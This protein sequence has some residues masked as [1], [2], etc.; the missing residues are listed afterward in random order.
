[1]HGYIAPCMAASHAGRAALPRRRAEQQPSHA[2]SRHDTF[3]LTEKAEQQL[4]P[5]LHGYIVRW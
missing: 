1:M 5:T 2:D 3:S 4:R